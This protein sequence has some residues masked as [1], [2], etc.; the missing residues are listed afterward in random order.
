VVHNWGVHLL[1]GTLVSAFGIP[2]VNQYLRVPDANGHKT[3]F[4]NPELGLAY[5]AYNTGSWH[6]W[7]GLDLVPPAPSYHKSDLVNIGQH[8]FSTVPLAAF[9]YLPGHGATEISSRLQYLVNYTNHA[10][11]YRSG[12]EFTW[13]YAAMHNIAKKLAIG[14]NGYYYQQMTDD[15]QNGIR[16]G[17][18]N[19]GRDFAAGPQVRYHFGRVALIA[20]YQRDTLVQNRAHGNAFW[21]ELGVPLGHP[22]VSR[23]SVAHGMPSQGGSL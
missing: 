20:K 16:F 4:S 8:Y 1:G 12:N 3:G 2:V 17:E 13:E 18:G 6:W 5:V 14:V 21:F 22:R 11:N 10:T 19:R 7:Y 15:L 23:A 9:T